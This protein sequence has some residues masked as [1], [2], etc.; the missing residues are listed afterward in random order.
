MAEDLLLTGMRMLSRSLCEFN[1][2][3]LLL[4]LTSLSATN[5]HAH[6][7]RVIMDTFRSFLVTV[8]LPEW[9]AI[10]TGW[11]AIKYAWGTACVWFQTHV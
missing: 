2:E 3:F 9:T 8:P 4:S 5:V 11:N 7:T 6:L 10:R 1:L